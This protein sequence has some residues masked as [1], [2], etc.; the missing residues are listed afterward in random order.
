MRS[1]I[2]TAI[3]G[4]YDRLQQPVRQRTDC[5]FLCFTDADWPAR[6]GAWQIVRSHRRRGLHPRLRAKYFKVMSHEVFPDGCLAWRYRPFGPRPA[7]DRLIWIDG[8]L[9]I[10][11]PD[12]A[13]EFGAHVGANGWSMFVHPDRACIYDE[14]QAS[15][16]MLKYRGLPLAAQIEAYR[17]EGF[18]A[19]AGLMA[20]GL[21]ARDPHRKTL[22]GI[23]RAWWAENL[24][25]SYQDQLSLPVVLWRLGRSFDPVRLDLW[26]N[27]WFDRG[28]HLS[29]S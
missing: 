25:W 28:D 14:L 4:G 24:R 9:T 2:Y 7:Y 11:S 22:A 19:G 8:C 10:K 18:P 3:Y 12:F 27:A 23:N 6:I 1:C 29:E 15:A 13:A 5:D 16:G 17:Q 26:N 21:I 20:G